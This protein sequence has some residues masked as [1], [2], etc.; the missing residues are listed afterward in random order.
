MARALGLRPNGVE[1]RADHEI[2]GDATTA[3]L[4][5]LSIDDSVHRLLVHD[6]VIRIGEDPE[7]VHRRAVATRRL[8]SD[9][10]TFR[11]ILDVAWSDDL[12]EELRWFGAALGGVRD[13]DVLSDLLRTTLAGLADADRAQAGELLDQLDAERDP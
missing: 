5:R 9:L 1:P 6:P 4:V 3:E 11:P 8:R 10:R 7:G 2:G 12:R 13:A